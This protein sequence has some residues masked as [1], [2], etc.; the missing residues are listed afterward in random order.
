VRILHAVHYFPP[1]THGGTQE[2]VAEL[3]SLQRDDGHEVGVIA[4]ARDPAKDGAVRASEESGVR[5]W[6]VLRDLPAESL[7]GDLGCARIGEVF[8]R[9]AADFAPDLVHVH[10]W[11]ALTRDLVR[12]AKRLGVPVVVTLHDLFT[13]CPRF[14]RMPDHKSLCERDLTFADCA[15]CVSPDAGGVPVAELEA[16]LAE[17]AD[18]LRRELD[19]ADAVLAV[20]AAQAGFLRSLAVFRCEDVRVLP[21]G[22]RFDAPPPPA[23]EPAPGR[24]RIVSWAGL[25]PRKGIQDLL[26]A[27]AAS[28]RRGA[29]EVH[30][31]GRDGEPEYMAELRRIADG[32]SVRFHGP[33]PDAERVAFA[34]R[35]DVAVFPFLAFETHGLAVDEA[36]HAGLPVVVSDRGAPPARI[37]GRGRTFPAGDP[38]ALMRLLEEL[39]DDPGELARMRRA[40][41]GAVDLRTHHRALAEAY[42]AVVAGQAQES[43]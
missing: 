25:D 16:L 9:L 3:A 30:L 26:A 35:Y 34:E 24:L 17:R 20:S 18:E 5:V 22:I 7:S 4:G 32:S 11:H 2:Y 6:R 36:L 12:R 28:R 43:A 39:L 23:P 10:H 1:E 40:P 37:G 33:F 27:V 8:A 29:F 14:F 38:Q 41:H 15:A 31:H 21:I 13:T 42:S 19:A